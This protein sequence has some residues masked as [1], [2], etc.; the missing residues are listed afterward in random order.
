MEI[1]LTTVILPLLCGLVSAVVLASAPARPYLG[2]AC[3]CLSCLFVYS[4]L[5]GFPRPI[6]INASQKL[7]DA[8]LVAAPVFWVLR[9]MSS[10]ASAAIAF[11]MSVTL[12]GWL[13]W[14]RLHPDLSIF[15]FWEAAV[16]IA[17]ASLAK[18]FDREDIA[19]TDQIISI[20]VFALGLSI[21]AA[22]AP[23][24]GFAQVAMAF[25][26]YSLTIAGF[27]FCYAI[28]AHRVPFPFEIGV[29][30]QYLALAVVGAAC[31]VGGFAPDVNRYAFALLPFAL[32]APSVCRRFLRRSESMHSI[33]VGLS[34]ALP[35]SA[36]ALLAIHNGS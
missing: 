4:G 12:L 35:V 8:L 31:V 10:K 7:F 20:G 22:F 28:L 24:V 23:F 17:I 13:M 15:T 16:P 14:R 36:A 2:Y 29:S 32:A 5:Q 34:A 19:A 9:R 25:G 18:A 30:I 3:V 26:I 27:A 6:P 1:V 33:V 21:I 11:V